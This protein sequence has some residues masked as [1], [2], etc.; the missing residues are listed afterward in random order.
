MGAPFNERQTEMS[1]SEVFEKVSQLM[2]DLYDLDKSQITP[3]STFESLDLT[4]L[5]AID[6]IVD[7]QQMLGKKVDEDAFKKI[8]TVGDVVAL[9][10]KEI[11]NA[12]AQDGQKSA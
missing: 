12:P 6:L 9:I 10:E 4:S 1:S 5:D 2:V 7:L 3:E 8:R 11:A